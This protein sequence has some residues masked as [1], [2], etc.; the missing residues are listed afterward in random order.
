MIQ[1]CGNLEFMCSEEQWR[2][3]FAKIK[4]K[5]IRCILDWALDTNE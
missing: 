3:K 4:K 1:N 2:G 5:I